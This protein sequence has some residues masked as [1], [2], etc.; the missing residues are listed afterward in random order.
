MGRSLF[1]ANTLTG[2]GDGA[3]D[4][5][6]EENMEDG[7]LAICIDHVN[8]KVYCYT[9]ESDSG[10][11]ESSPDVISPDGATS[12]KRWILIDIHG[13]DII[14][15]TTLMA[16]TAGTTINE[17]STDGT[18]SGN[19]DNAVPTEK[20]VKT[21]ID[22]LSSGALIWRT[23]LMPGFVIR[24]IF[25]WSDLDTI[26]ISGGGS[27]EIS[28]KDKL[29]YTNAQITFDLGSGGS[30]ADSSDISAGAADWHYLYID[31]STLTTTQTLVAANFLNSTTEPS[32]DNTKC[33]WYN[34]NDRCIF[35]LYDDG[36][37]AGLRQFYHIGGDFV[38]WDNPY[39]TNSGSAF[40]STW[41][42][43]DTINPVISYETLITIIFNYV[44][45][46]GSCLIRPDGNF[47]GTRF[48]YIAADNDR[49]S[50]FLRSQISDANLRCEITGPAGSNTVDVYQRG[51][52]MGRGL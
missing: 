19:S 25:E 8:E 33:G 32:W 24:S 23:D 12:D 4:A 26:L 52:C 43:I 2:G 49:G 3:L 29:Y 11:A 44:D 30:N 20:A 7:D 46:A 51:W 35:A 17:F 10:V 18:L 14:A 47:S 21:Y 42:D 48:G 39:T 38:I 15:L 6:A 5:I 9:C 36:S 22:S 41:L 50:Y 27:W 45:A 40:N 16:G 13:E 37:S 1:W 31:Y 34:G 28:G